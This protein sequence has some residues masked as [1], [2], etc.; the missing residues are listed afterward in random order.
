MPQIEAILTS[1]PVAIFLLWWV[2]FIG[3]QKG[4]DKR[5]N[6]I[7]GEW[8][9]INDFK[10]MKAY[11]MY[12]KGYNHAKKGLPAEKEWRV[13]FDENYQSTGEKGGK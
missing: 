12:H 4:Y 2:Y 3:E 6:L 13:L 9:T 10:N 7:E 8:K 1:I 11:I 5:C